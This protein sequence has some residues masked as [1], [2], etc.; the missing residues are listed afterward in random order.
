M[1]RRGWLRSLVSIAMVASALAVGTSPAGAASR[2]TGITFRLSDARKAQLTALQDGRR[3]SMLSSSARTMIDVMLHGTQQ[4]EPSAAAASRSIPAAPVGANVRVN[5]PSGDGAFYVENTTQSETTI[6]RSGGNIVV[7]FND[8]GQLSTGA[9]TGFTGYAVSTDGGASFQDHTLANPDWGLTF[10]DPVMASDRSGDVYF[11]MLS[12]D[13]LTG[14]TPLAVYRS[15]DHGV[16][17]SNEALLPPLT[18]PWAFVDKPWLTVGPNPADPS[19][20]IVYA[21]WT[22][23]ARKTTIVVTASRDQGAT[24]STPVP[25]ARSTRWRPN[26]H[27]FRYT[28][29][30]GLSLAADPSTGRLYASWLKFIIS[31][32]IPTFESDVHPISV[33]ASDDGGRHWTDPVTAVRPVA[34]KQDDGLCGGELDF[35]PGSPVRTINFPTM[36]VGNAGRLFL[37]VQTLGSDGIAHITVSRS[38]DGGQTWTRRSIDEPD[39]AF[40][41][42][43]AADKTGVSV[44]YYLRTGPTTM[45]ARLATSGFAGNAFTPGPLGDTSFGVPYTLPDFDPVIAPCYM[46]D[47]NSVLRAGA[48]TYAAWGDNRDTVVDGVWPDGRPDPNVYFG[49]V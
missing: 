25:I 4:A 35:G 8:D 6:A 3:G 12:G 33:V 48:T 30:T 47:Y 13:Y 21:G 28:D 10:G 7:G 22:E 19:K 43:I 41:P 42:A 37:A 9:G 34:I 40:M 39:D 14:G 49:K 23:F 2:S 17:F 38:P 45:T 16:T 31:S 29:P 15:T 11:A 26:R 20:D 46:G 24:W 44:M 27:E 36:A 5:D 18:S 32:D 1:A